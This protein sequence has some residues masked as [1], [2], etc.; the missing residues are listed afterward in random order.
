MKNILVAALVIATAALCWAFA[1]FAVSKYPLQSPVGGRIAAQ[2][3]PKDSA[4]GNAGNPGSDN[5]NQ[6]AHRDVV[7]ASQSQPA[8]PQAERDER[9]EQDD[10]K[11]QQSMASSAKIAWIVALISAGITLLGVIY[12]KRTL[13]ATVGML[14]QAQETTRISQKQLMASQRPWLRVEIDIGGPLSNTENQTTVTVNIIVTNI[15]NSPAKEVSP[16][17]GIYIAALPQRIGYGHPPAVDLS[18]ERVCRQLF[19]PKPGRDHAILFPN[20]KIGFT[21]TFFNSRLVV[22]VPKESRL[23]MFAYGSAAYKFD[24]SGGIHRTAVIREIQ[25]KVLTLTR[26]NIFDDG[27]ISAVEME[28][29]RNFYCD[30]F[31]N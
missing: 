1:E 15:G 10:L 27:E 18:D 28:M 31:A 25:R 24:T 4:Q 13:D 30:D 11:A 20:D 2:Q 19:P 7:N 5:H 22:D 6:G 12:V 26:Q 21:H 3:Y 9:R 17:V 8:N 23:H 29:D 14:E 16:N